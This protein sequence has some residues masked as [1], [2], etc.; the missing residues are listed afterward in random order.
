MLYLNGKSYLKKEYPIRY[1]ALKTVVKKSK[2]VCLANRIVTD[3]IKIM[4]KFFKEMINRGSEGIMVKSRG[5]DSVYKAGTRGWLWIKWKKEYIKDMVDTF[6]LVVV[7]AF[8]GRGRRA[9][10]YGSLL[11]AVYNKKKNCFETFCKLGTGF[12]DEQLKNLPKKFKV[13]KQKH[14]LV[15]AKKAMKPDVWFT[16]AIVVEV[17]GAEITKSPIHTAEGLALRFPRFLRYRP[18]KSPEQATTVKEIK[19][20]YR[21]K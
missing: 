5:K 8:M 3:D 4:Q 16:P 20:M 2:G 11:C 1:S 12:T 13:I 9:G 10:K 17:L 15:N 19:Q 21:K 7:G 6:D 18:E 14:P